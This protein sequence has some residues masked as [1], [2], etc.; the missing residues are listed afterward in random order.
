MSTL[1]FGREWDGE[2]KAEQSNSDSLKTL[3]GMPSVFRILT[4][5]I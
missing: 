3:T 4:S 2:W 1:P 5:S